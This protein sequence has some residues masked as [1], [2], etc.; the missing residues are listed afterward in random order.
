MNI[1]NI[2]VYFASGRIS[3]KIGTLI[4]GDYNSSKLVFEFDDDS[5]VKMFELLKPDGTTKWIKEIINNE[6]I[7]TDTDELNKTIPLLSQ[8]GTYIFE[9]AKYDN[10]SKLTSVKGKFKVIDEQ[11]NN[12]DIELEETSKT[13]F[14]ELINDIIQS[15]QESEKQASYAQQQGD[16]AKSKAES[17]ILAT[18]AASAII[19]EFSN[20]LDQYTSTFDSNATTKT[21]E[22]NANCLEKIEEYN[23]NATTKTNEFNANITSMRQ[24]INDCYNNMPMK[25]IVDFPANITDS[26]NFDV[27]Q[28]I[29][30]GKSSQQSTPSPTSPQEIESINSYNL[31]DKENVN[32]ING[33]IQPSTGKILGSSNDKC[34]YVS[35]EGGKT[36]T[37]SKI[38]SGIFRIGFTDSLPAINST[39]N[40]L[41]YDNN[42][43]SLTLKS[44]ASN[45]YLVVDYFVNNNP[46]QEQDILNSIVIEE[47][48]IAHDYMPYKTAISI[49][50]TQNIQQ[51]IVNVDLAE[52]E[53]RS[54]GNVEDQ[55]I[56]QKKN[57][58]LVQKT[59]KIVLEGRSDENYLYVSNNSVN[60]YSQI[61]YRNK[62]DNIDNS[63]SGSNVIC[64]H[65]KYYVSAHQNIKQDQGI[66]IVEAST[67]FVFSIPETLA[68][69]VETFRSWLSQNPI[70]IIYG[71]TD[72]VEVDLGVTAMPRTYKNTT[73]IT[74]SAKL[75]TTMNLTYVQDINT[76]IQNLTSSSSSTIVEEN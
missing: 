33:Y 16:Y 69:S 71:I 38:L 55:V 24:Q 9:I 62:I 56:L 42:V 60:G 6:I 18:D 17:V 39:C 12:S 49:K 30:A 41:T 59:G 67:P 7:L 50:S 47:G 1:Y 13:E 68:N 21:N 4:K 36:Y 76:V 46:A 45:N 70:T 28:V 35:I 10:N 64:S 74:L 3:Y 34:L 63:N 31:F 23:D 25:N 65:F 53:A 61:N 51:N 26:A 52:N 20:D 11:V 29:V 32:V 75:D 5:G 43:Q 15:I 22:F 54:A 40:P 44:N 73:N 72:E 58:K 19:D 27:E 37:V 14:D 8:E 57:V 2:K 48:S 66:R